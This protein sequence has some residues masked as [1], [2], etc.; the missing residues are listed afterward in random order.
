MLG[1]VPRTA[2]D[3]D[4]AVFGIPVRVHPIFWLSAAFLGYVPRRLDLTVVG[5]LC[6]FFAILI[7]ELGHAIVT[8]RFGWSPEIVLY[9]LGGYAT[10][11]RHSSWRSIAVSAAGPG[12]GLLLFAAAWWFDRQL[13][14]DGVQPGQELLAHAVNI[15]VFINLLWSIMNLMPVLPLDGGHICRDFCAWLSPRN[16]ELTAL[17]ISIAT[18]GI[19]ALY[20]AYC[21]RQRI[22]FFGLQASFVA[23]MFGY[24]CYQGY[25]S[26]Q[27]S[28]RG[29]R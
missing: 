17:K 6:I 23:I 8:R 18:S 4:F 22:G 24:L 14:R 25:Q 13:F 5:V 15:S 7:H 28:S 21:W 29:Y 2:Y 9:F 20:A 19:I 12:A 3:L 10:T 27:N 16:G 1:Q 26:L 11:T